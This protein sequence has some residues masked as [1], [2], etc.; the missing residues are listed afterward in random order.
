MLVEALLLFAAPPLFEAV[1][2][3]AELALEP[4]ELRELFFCPADEPVFA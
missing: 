3:R 4:F 2:R 1:E